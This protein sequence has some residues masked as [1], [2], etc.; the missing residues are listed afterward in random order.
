MKKLTAFFTIALLVCIATFVAFASNINRD[1]SISTLVRAQ[2]DDNLDIPGV[3]V[4][5]KI[6]AEFN[7]S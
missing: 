6:K 4:E 3:Q 5:I 1:T 7:P 2:P